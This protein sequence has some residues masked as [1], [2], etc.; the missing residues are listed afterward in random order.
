M[1]PEPRRI[2]PLPVGPALAVVAGLG[3]VT[4]GTFA[5]AGIA[6]VVV[7]VAGIVG[8]EAIGMP[9]VLD[10]LSRSLMGGVL[11]AVGAALL[12]ELPRGILERRMRLRAAERRGSGPDAPRLPRAEDRALREEPYGGL[13][14]LAWFAVVLGPVVM[15]V[16]LVSG[17][18]FDGIALGAGAAITLGAVGLFFAHGGL[19]RRWTARVE[20]VRG[21]GPGT[22]RR[23]GTARAATRRAGAA[24]KA[25]GWRVV[26][27]FALQ[28]GVY[29]FFAGVILRQP[30][31]GCDQIDYGGGPMEGVVDLLVGLGGLLILIP[32]ALLLAST[33]PFL[34]RTARA[35]RR[36][37]RDARAG[38]LQRS[39]D[40][41]S[42]LTA[43]GWLTRLA[44]GLATV[45]ALL[46]LLGIA[47]WTALVNDSASEDD[48]GAL[49]GLS[50]LLAPG[51]GV[52]VAGLAAG[53]AGAVDSRAR[54][55]AIL[56]ALGDVG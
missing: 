2:E 5:A 42:Q 19:A 26:T 45:G 8:E 6:F 38:T 14:V 55:A 10:V 4:I 29:A 12:V 36:I 50:V 7:L 31:R 41:L 23:G 21:P 24:T 20:R 52:L 15:L 54:R 49:A 51:V 30:C 46:V 16:D 40:V 43:P 27:G 28:L 33:V 35:E 22:R 3:A 1:S 11:L 9:S 32:V 56:A 17:F 13:L 34:L 25:I 48:V 47:P 37:V 44:Y 18:D 53:I 39:D